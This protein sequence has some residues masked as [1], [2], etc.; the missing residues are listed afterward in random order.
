MTCRDE[1]VERVKRVTG[2]DHAIINTVFWALQPGDEIGGGLRVA[3][4]TDDEVEM[5]ADDVA[6]VAARQA[7]EDMRERI[8]VWIVD[9]TE[10]GD[11]LADTIRSL[12]LPGDE[13]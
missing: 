7:A 5:L 9:H 4:Y 8:A 11:E 10:D 13:T 6:D 12:P 2:L 3:S 1:A